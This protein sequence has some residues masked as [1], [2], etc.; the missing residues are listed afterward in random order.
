MQ[1][2]AMESSEHPRVVDPAQQITQLREAV[3]E[4]LTY[5]VGKDRNVASERDWF[6]ATAL[7]VRD[8]IVERWMALGARRPTAKTASGSITCRWNS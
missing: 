2:P 3:L 1:D 7:A 5:S 8:R 4:K 6:V